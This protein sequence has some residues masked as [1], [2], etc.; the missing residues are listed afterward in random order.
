MRRSRRVARDGV[1]K[2]EGVWEVKGLGVEGVGGWWGDSMFWDVSTGGGG[3]GG[4]IIGPRVGVG[5]ICASP[6]KRARGE[7]SV[8][9]S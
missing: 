4:V 2:G 5:V 3:G 7:L 1:E 8:W 6:E 9:K